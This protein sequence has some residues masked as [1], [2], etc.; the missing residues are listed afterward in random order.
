LR[1]LCEFFETTTAW[2]N[3]LRQWPTGALVRFMQMGE[4]MKALLGIRT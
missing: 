2:Y 4:R 1:E 3:Q